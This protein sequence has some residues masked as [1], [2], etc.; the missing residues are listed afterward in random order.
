MG[1][2]FR[3]LI[4]LWAV[5]VTP[6]LFWTA[7]FDMFEQPK[8]LAL[9]TAAALVALLI[10]PA[11][12][13]TA[14]FAAIAGLLG[15][16]LVSSIISPLPWYSFFGEYTSYQGWLHWL[17]LGVLIIALT[18]HLR[19]S[20]ETRR[21]LAAAGVSG[22]LVSTYA[23]VQLAGID[24][25]VW[26]NGGAVFR[27]FSTAG[28]PLYL[29]FLLAA[30]VPVCIGLARTSAGY[31]QR[32]IW[33]FIALITFFGALSSG[34]RSAA[35]G[36]LIGSGIM[37]IPGFAGKSAG[38]FPRKT[39]GGLLL[40]VIVF[41]TVILPSNRNPASVLAT[42]LNQLVHEG[43]SRPLIWAGASRLIRERPLSGYG[44]DTFATFHPR[45]Q[46]PRLWMALWHA[47]PEKAHNEFIQAASTAGIP[48]TGLLIWLAVWMASLAWRNR[49]EPLIACAGAGITAMAL[50]A[51]FGFIT[52]GT[53]AIAVLLSAVLLSRAHGGIKSP[54]FAL[55]L[56][57]IILVVSLGLHLHFASSLV[58]LKN[59]VRDGGKG[60]EQV[61][62]LRTPW[63]QNLLQ[64][65]DM[66]ERG[67]FGPGLTLVPA[68]DA[69]IRLLSR[70]YGQTLSANPLHAF[71]RSAVGR[72]KFREGKTAEALLSYEIARKL[73]P[74][75]VYLPM[76]ESQMLISSR[77]EAEGITLLEEAS[78]MYP[79]FGE[80]AG[81]I[82]YL[83]MAKKKPGLAEPWLRKA[84]EGEWYGNNAAAYAAAINLVVLYQNVN[85]FNEAAWAESMARK[86]AP[87]GTLK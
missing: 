16:G 25:I 24:P 70:L 41:S 60:M 65:G 53:Q 69:R 28:N 4:L 49:T 78:E 83:L 29:G 34:S 31:T 51:L 79:G 40:A 80:P 36:A 87:A 3:R 12:I 27:A 20:G 23:L 48:A 86:Y 50:P 26:N 6:L 33:L 75:D 66:L 13:P 63:A 21:F 42:R 68:D 35:A 73:A 54:A 59:S 2:I 62:A 43:D 15:L 85:R 52:C 55:K 57:G 9:K 1:F 61:L 22:G 8:Q 82:G 39:I 18:S 46:S 72:V 32:H 58:A 7:S 19:K 5:A 38:A 44:L 84:V 77:R 30:L 76:E 67:W 56:T 64:S 81:M 74:W 14:L 45:V 17:A 71:A 11:T 37:I 10:F 47:S